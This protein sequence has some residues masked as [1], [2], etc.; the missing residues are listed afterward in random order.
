[1]VEW[2]NVRSF[3]CRTDNAATITFEVVFQENSSDVLFNYQDTIFG[4]ACM[5]EDEGQD[6]TIGLQP[7]PTTGVDVATP[8]QRFTAAGTAILWQSPPPSRPA[9]PTPVLTS[10][11]PNSAPLLSGDL[12]LTARGSG[13][14]F[15][16]FVQWNGT[17]L[18]TTF[19]SGTQLTASLPATLFT[20]FSRYSFGG[21]VQ[22]GVLNP[23]PG[24]GLSNSLPFAVLATGVPSI[25]SIS[26]SAASAGGFSFVLDVRGNNL[27]QSGI[28]WNNQLLDTFVM[29][30][31][32]A[33][34]AV[35]SGLIA[36]P[37]VAHITAS[38]NA[39]G[40]GTSNVANLTIGPAANQVLVSSSSSAKH[41][42]VDSSGKST[43]DVGARRP[44]RFLGWNY[45][46]R[47]GGPAYLK[48]FSRPYGG[49]MPSLSNQTVEQTLRKPPHSQIAQSVPSLT[50]PASL[51]G[52]AFQPTLPAG[53]LPSSVATGDFNHDGKMDWVVSNAGTNDLWLYLGNG[54]GTAQLPIIIPLA[55]ISP[56]KVVAADLR[57]TG[58]LDLV[59]AEADSGTVGILLG[60]NNGTFVPEVLY[61][62]PA[63]VFT[64]TAADVNGD[65]KLDVVAGI[66]G[67]AETGPVI[68]LLGDGTGR[69]G[70]IHLSP[71]ENF[72]GV[73]FTTSIV[74]KD[75]NGDSLPDLLVIDES[76]SAGGAH[77]YLSR[78]D[79]SFK[80]AQYLAV[81][82][83][84]FV[85]YTSAAVGDMD[86]DGCADA[87]IG[88]ALGLVTVFKGNCD[89]SFQDL[90]H[91]IVVGAGEAPVSLALSDMN[92]DGHLDVVTAGGVFGVPP[93]FGWEATNL[94]TVLLGDGSGNLNLAKVYRNQ[95]SMF[96]LALA[97]LNGDNRPDVIA[98]S[99][100]DDSV[101]APLND[102]HGVLPGAF[103]RI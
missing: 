86:E 98:A 37:G 23:A 35:P 6:A 76:V 10:I 75:L 57:G 22:V 92:G 27:Y 49:T 65:G 99:Q 8:N 1:M 39:P 58:T 69:F 71:V 60:N 15:G 90:D 28:Y 80:H 11:S 42:S 64:V 89:G 31:T 4:G 34:A 96:G 63:P 101:A 70:A 85:F 51:P 41:Q 33:T 93:G 83:D 97:D 46:A 9:N 40:G 18:P 12:T 5:D 32:E 44:E 3:L 25:T 48:R 68:T 54:D 74:A 78:G 88:Q 13:F 52:F 66:L 14:V 24:G 45:G 84:N 26:P 59:V 38:I 43:V 36:S 20:L 67:S 72:I 17:N 7:S 100:D 19:V 16:S 91:A 79:G 56:L 77:S 81:D 55:G 73:L 2:R 103:W 94:V 47:Q 53:F 102:G 21:T 61:P 82:S 95:P 30:N 50:Q 87:V 62:L 29:S